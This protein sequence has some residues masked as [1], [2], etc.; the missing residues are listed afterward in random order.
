MRPSVDPAASDG[1]ATSTAEVSACLLDGVARAVDALL[2]LERDLVRAVVREPERDA[3]LACDLPRDEDDALR[4]AGERPH[5]VR[6]GRGH[7]CGGFGRAQRVGADGLDVDVPLGL[8]ELDEALLRLEALEIAGDDDPPLLDRLPR[9]V[10]E[11]ALSE[12]H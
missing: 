9:G 8:E 6:F 7:R 12:E 11:A 2:R 5:E 4:S 1:E 10:L 3:R